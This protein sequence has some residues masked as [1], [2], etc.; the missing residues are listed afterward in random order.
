MQQRIALIRW[1]ESCPS[2]EDWPKRSQVVDATHQKTTPAVNARLSPHFLRYT[3]TALTVSHC[4][5][6]CRDLHLMPLHRA[7]L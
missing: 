1:W 6:H 2:P 3:I 5:A 4:R 7:D